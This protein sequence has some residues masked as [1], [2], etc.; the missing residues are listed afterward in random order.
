MA[1][2]IGTGATI[3]FG[4]TA[5]ALIVESIEHSGISRESI[6]VSHLA[7]TGGRTMI[8]GD[9]YNPGEIVIEGLLEQLLIDEM[10]TKIGAVAE[11]I[12]VTLPDTGTI[13]AS[14][15]VKEMEYG[16]PLDDKMTFSMTI[17][18]SDE[19]TATPSA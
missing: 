3:T 7:T 8:P 1:V 6:D 2:D 9:L 14:G 18:L 13:A 11:T 16:I 5:I 10:V 4:S 12:T 15:F 19:I 17:Q